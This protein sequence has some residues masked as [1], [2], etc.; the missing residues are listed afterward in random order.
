MSEFMFGLVI[1]LGSGGALVWLFHI[2]IRKAK[3]ALEEGFSSVKSA[4]KK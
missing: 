2:P 3:K 1:G 4:V